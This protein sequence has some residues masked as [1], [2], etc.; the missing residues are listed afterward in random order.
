MR[1]GG[2]AFLGIGGEH[3]RP[4]GPEDNKLKNAMIAEAKAFWFRLRVTLWAVLTG[5]GWFDWKDFMRKLEESEFR[6]FATRQER[7]CFGW[8]GLGENG[9]WLFGV[10]GYTV[11]LWGK[12]VMRHELFHA[13]Q[14]HMTGLFTKSLTFRLALMAEYSAHLW[15]GPL[16]G[17]V[18]YVVPVAFVAVCTLFAISLGW[19]ITEIWTA[20]R[21]Q[22]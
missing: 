19:L 9:R 5:R 3:P 10:A 4:S 2:W 8:A 6:E 21:L 7:S 17:W 13:A 1:I 15:G 20:R 22:R 11:P 12:S 14:D 16:I 18:V